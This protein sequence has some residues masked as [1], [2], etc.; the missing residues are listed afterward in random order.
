MPNVID[1]RSRIIF[2]E[3]RPRSLDDLLLGHLMPIGQVLIKPVGGK[4]AMKAFIEGYLGDYDVEGRPNYLGFR[5]RDF[6]FEPPEQPQLIRLP[7]EKPIWLSHRTVIENYFIDAD[8]I[9]QYRLERENAPGWS[10]GPALSKAEIEG[11]ILQSAAEL[12]GYQ[13]V[14]WALSKLK[15]GLRWPEIPTTWMANGS[16]HIPP[17]LAYEDCLIR[18]CQLVVSF[19]DQIR[20]VRPEV[21]QG[22]AEEFRK[23]FNE[24]DFLD[25]GEYLIW[26]H[27]KDHLVRLCPRL[28][29]NFPRRHYIAWAAEHIDVQ[30]HPDLLEL[31][32]LVQEP[33]S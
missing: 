28:A 19:Q 1:P 23:K 20:D 22:F 21:L 12:V 25:E 3:G 2:C 11:H 27:G 14:R 5:D 9:R 15:P 18:A 31:K 24:E 7:G 4:R 10:Y 30:K 32:D 33:F 26:F 13:A 6:D 29:S 16:G 17:S 8:L